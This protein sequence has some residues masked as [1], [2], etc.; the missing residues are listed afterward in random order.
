MSLNLRLTEAGTKFL[1]QC[2][3]GHVDPTEPVL[4][5][6]GYLQNWPITTECVSLKDWYK[7]YKKDYEED[8]GASC[9]TS[10]AEVLAAVALGW[11]GF[12][13]S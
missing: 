9:P 7:A 10:E 1:D 5:L 2:D 4:D 12:Y 8:L 13:F 6:L 11:V 3:G